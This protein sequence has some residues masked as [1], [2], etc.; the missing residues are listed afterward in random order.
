MS[1]PLP[2]DSRSLLVL[3]ASV[4]GSS[5]DIA[6]RIG[7]RGRRAGWS[8]SVKGVAQFDQVRDPFHLLEE[9]VL[10]RLE[11]AELLT[12]PLI[13]FV[14]PTTGNGAAPPS[15]VPLWTSLLHPALPSD[16]LEDLR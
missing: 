12:S 6:E 14:L 7:R 13:V 1:S 16:L 11:Q 3:H 2:L 4:T 9:H 8:V 5:I 15:F 10:M